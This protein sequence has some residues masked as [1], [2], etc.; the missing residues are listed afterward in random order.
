MVH[1]AACTSA[2]SAHRFEQEFLN[3]VFRELEEQLA[4]QQMLLTGALNVMEGRDLNK[5]D[6]WLATAKELNLGDSAEAQTVQRLRS[7]LV[8]DEGLVKQLCDVSATKKKLAARP[9]WPYLG[10]LR[11]FLD[12]AMR[13]ACLQS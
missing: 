2:C 9:S 11:C 5:I 4:A 13:T 8:E 10:R 1:V 12:S 7:T 6:D 3:T